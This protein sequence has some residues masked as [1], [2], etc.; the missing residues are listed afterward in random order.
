[1]LRVCEVLSVE[2]RSI[3]VFLLQ[4]LHAIIPSSASAS[5]S[6]AAAAAASIR[7]V[8]LCSSSAAA[9]VAMRRRTSRPFPPLSVSFPVARRRT[10]N[11]IVEGV[12]FHRQASFVTRRTIA[13]FATNSRAGRS[14]GVDDSLHQIPFFTTVVTIVVAAAVRRSGSGSGSG[15][16]A[17]TAACAVTTY[18]F[19]VFFAQ[20]HITKVHA[21]AISVLRKGHPQLVLVVVVVGSDDGF[22]PSRLVLLVAVDGLHFTAHREMAFLQ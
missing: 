13:I 14:L 15:A 5:S 9:A 6:I 7:V 10:S 2:S 16:G 4:H 20:L 3:A 21:L 8:G 1:M 19:F 18:F 17:A 22:V 12:G 11:A